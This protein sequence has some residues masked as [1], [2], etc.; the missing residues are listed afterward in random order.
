MS[1]ANFEFKP[2]AETIKPGTTITWRNDDSIAHTVT[3]DN[4]IFDSGQIAPGSTFSYTFAKS[5][6]YPYHCSVHPNMAG[7]I[8]VQ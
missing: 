5:G 4:A 7:L 1:I 3:S 2:P 6:Q 8:T